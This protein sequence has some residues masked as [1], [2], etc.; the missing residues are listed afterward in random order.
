MPLTCGFVAEDAGFEPA[1]VL[2]QH[3]FQVCTRPFGP[4]RQRP[5]VLG[6]PPKNLA[7]RPRTAANET[8]NE[9]GEDRLAA[10]LVGCRGRPSHRGSIH[11]T[12]QLVVIHGGP[13]AAVRLASTSRPRPGPGLSSRA[14][15]VGDALA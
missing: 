4:V 14:E 12:P 15:V 8:G 3:D 10:A 9:T 1:R 5:V 6:D 11:A 7:D 13:A 2:P